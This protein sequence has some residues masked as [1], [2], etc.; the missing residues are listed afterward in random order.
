M[1]RRNQEYMHLSNEA[2]VSWWSCRQLSFYLLFHLRRYREAPK[3][4]VDWC[5]NKR[6]WFFS[7]IVAVF[8]H[9]L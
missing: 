2:V 1:R 7:V 9:R 6:N 8:I 5:R 3:K 4:I